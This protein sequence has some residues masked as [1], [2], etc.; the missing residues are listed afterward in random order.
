MTNPNQ[1]HYYPSIFFSAIFVSSLIPPKKRVP[2][3]HDP[4]FFP[5]GN[6]PPWFP[7][8]AVLLSLDWK[9]WATLWQELLRPAAEQPQRTHRLK[10]RKW[11]VRKLRATRETGL[12]VT[13]MSQGN[14]SGIYTIQYIIYCIYI[15]LF[16]YIYI[17]VCVYV[18]YRAIMCNHTVLL[19]FGTV[20]YSESLHKRETVRKCSFA[21][22]T[23]YSG[24]CRIRFHILMQYLESKGDFL[25]L[26][27]LCTEVPAS[28]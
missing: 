20:C 25:C 4:C 28:P 5:G 24:W 14:G 26:L 8:L 27:S 23:L 7:W 22:L 19:K 3:F 15:F 2:F 13:W 9:P 16:M 17:Y 21:V 1:L 11:W 10:N 6:L 12:E 18:L